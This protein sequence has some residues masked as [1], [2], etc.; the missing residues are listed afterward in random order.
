MGLEEALLN[1]S[2]R[3]RRRL[4]WRFRC[5]FVSSAMALFRHLRSGASHGQTDGRAVFFLTGVEAPRFTAGV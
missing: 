4:R 2:N 3:M 5:L 1:F